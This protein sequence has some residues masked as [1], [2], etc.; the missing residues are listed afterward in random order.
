M[1]KINVYYRSESKDKTQG[2]IWVK[3]YV[4]S[5]KVNFSTKIKF[6]SD[7]WDAVKCM[8]LM[9]DKEA[10]DKNLI[11]SN[12]KARISDV[13]VKFMLK[14]R[15]LTKDGFLKAYSRPD[16]FDTFHEFCDFYK[17]EIGYLEAE[18]TANHKKALDKL[19]YLKPPKLTVN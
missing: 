13:F 18:T 11:I 14:N 6:F 2:Y 7:N 16:D 3:F 15:K 17:K 9:T 10:K 19:K 12:I 1:S 4:S 8:V 5:E